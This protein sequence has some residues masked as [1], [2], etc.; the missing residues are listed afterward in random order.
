MSWRMIRLAA[1]H[2]A[3]EFSGR[4][5]RFADVVMENL[6]GEDLA[7]VP[8]LAE[9]RDLALH[10]YGKGDIRP[11]RKMGHVNRI[12]RPATDGR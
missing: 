9:E 2:E 4:G 8:A 7:K 10:L 3:A 6:V 5:G 1:V 11:G 12:I